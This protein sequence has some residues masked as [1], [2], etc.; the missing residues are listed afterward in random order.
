LP[1]PAMGAGETNAAIAAASAA[2]PAWAAQT[3]AQRGAVLRRWNDLIVDNGDDLARIMVAE[4]GGVSYQCPSREC[5]RV[6][7]VHVCAH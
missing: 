2:F 1:D 5:V 7:V 6:C 4:Q 3:A